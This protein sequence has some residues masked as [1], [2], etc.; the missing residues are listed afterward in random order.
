MSHLPLHPV[1]VQRS[2]D[3]CSFDVLL[4]I[5]APH[6]LLLVLFLLLPPSPSRPPLPSPISPSFSP[7][8]SSVLENTGEQH[9]GSRDSIFVGHAP[10][11]LAGADGTKAALIGIIMPVEEAMIA[12]ASVPVIMMPQEEMKTSWAIS[13]ACGRA[14]RGDEE[15]IYHFV[16]AHSAR[17]SKDGMMSR[18]LSISNTPST[19]LLPIS[20]ATWA[21]APKNQHERRRQLI[22]ML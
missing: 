8:P 9:C 1:V 3:A 14:D 20:W 4:A 13:Q 16:S 7:L 22:T 11:D 2:F 15:S 12:S 10:S 6:H 21:I 5:I 18:P 19:S 17:S